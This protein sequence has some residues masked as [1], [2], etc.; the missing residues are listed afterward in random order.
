MKKVYQLPEW[1]RYSRHRSRRELQKRQERLARD[2]ALNVSREKRRI[3]QEPPHYDVSYRTKDHKIEIPV[4]E[5]FSILDNL[6][7]MLLFYRAIYAYALQNKKI[8]IQMSRIKQISVD[9]I[10]YTISVFEHLEKQMHFKSLSGNFPTDEYTRKVLI[11]SSFFNYVNANV[12]YVNPDN[13]EILSVKSDNLVRGKVAKQVIDFAK[14]QLG[15]DGDTGTKSMYAT[16]IECMVNT[17]HHAYESEHSSRK[18]WLM[19]LPTKDRKKIHFAILDN[20]KGIPT[21][22]QKYF[23]EKVLSLLG[24]KPQDSDLILS[25]LKGDYRTRMKDKWRGKGLPK[26]YSYSNRNLIE[27]L[28][29]VSNHGYVDCS[30]GLLK[31]SHERFHGTLLSWQ[32][33]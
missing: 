18:W 11:Q 6:D 13:S 31:E 19:A 14:A 25:A 23:G 16:L 4:P 24:N 8:Y 21:T 30:S 9:A 32:F 5:V 7:E 10:L 27:N 1:R 3:V 26:I 17:G 15:K 2:H 29:I 28:R 22:V 20:G 33:V 12:H